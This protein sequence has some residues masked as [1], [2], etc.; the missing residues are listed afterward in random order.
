[1]ARMCKSS[2]PTSPASAQGDVEDWLMQE[3]DVKVAAAFSHPRGAD[4]GLVKKVAG[5]DLDRVL[6][7]YCDVCTSEFMPGLLRSRLATCTAHVIGCP[8]M[9]G[10]R[11][12]AFV[13]PDNMP[14]ESFR[15]TVHGLWQANA[16]IWCD[17]SA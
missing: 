2:G 6:D 3:C 13:S 15:T 10:K 11:Y 14:A 9:Q 16:P 7:V 12:S 8:G 17:S 4:A 5:G 1:M